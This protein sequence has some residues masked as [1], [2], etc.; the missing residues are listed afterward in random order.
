VRI[1]KGS[2]ETIETYPPTLAQAS[3]TPTARIGTPAVAIPDAGS[4]ATVDSVS[5][6]VDADAYEGATQLTVTSATWV[7]GRK[8]L[9]TSSTGEVLP[10]VSDTDGA[11]DTLNLQEPLP[12]PLLTGS[13][14]KG[15]RISIALT[16]EQTASIGRCVVEWTA[17][18]NGVSEKW[19]DQFYVVE[20]DAGY[21]LDAAT[22][23]RFSAYAR[24]MKPET[25]N[26]LSETIAGA[27]IRY[28]AP[29]LLAKTIRPE[30]FVS[31]QEMIPAHIAACEHYC[32]QNA[33]SEEQE[34]KDEKR[35]EYGEALT[36]LLN[37]E[38]LWI[39]PDSEALTPPDPAAPRDWITVFVT[40]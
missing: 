13:T 25:D 40:R 18:L 16:A 6:T 17:T 38:T 9:A 14:I 34:T 37:S 33:T 39:N 32:A 35:R 10:I 8:Y 23:S 36:L 4:N 15:Y 19:P 5:T 21:A 20:R 2:T 12:A 3:G 27:W 29:A 7:K 30:L 26:D 31:R 28:L 22:L 11:S 1:I 24:R